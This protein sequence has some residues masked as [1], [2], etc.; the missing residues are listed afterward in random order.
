MTEPGPRAASRDR[1]ALTDQLLEIVHRLVRESHPG[2]TAPPAVALESRLD[3]DLG[4]DSMARAELVLRVERAFNVDLPEQALAAD[5]PAEL[6]EAIVSAHGHAS[7]DRPQPSP[8]EIPPVTGA[9]RQ[10]TTLTDALDWHLDRHADRP[11]LTIY[12]SDGPPETL[13]YAE[14][15]RRARTVA[16]GLTARGIR[17]GDALALMLPTGAEYFTAFLAALRIGAT[18]VPIYPPARASQLEE[19]LRRHGRILTNAEVRVL[20]TVAEARQV[21]RLLRAEAP[22]LEGIVTVDEL[23]RPETSGEDEAAGSD[24][25][26]LLQYTS[27]STGDP[28]GVTLTHAQLLANIRAMGER[29]DVTPEDVF[30]SW[31]PL[32]HD[33]GLIAAWLGSL[34]YAMPLVVM[35]PLGFLARPLRW[36]EIIH[37][38][39]GTISGGPN[40]GYELCLRAITSERLEGV[41]L[42]GWRVAFNGA[43]PV[44]PVTMERFA[45]AFAPHGFRREALMPVYGLA[46]AAVG[47]CVPTPGRGPVSDRVGRE[48]FVATGKAEPVHGDEPA[49]TFV[50][51]GPPLS[52]HEVRIVGAAGQELAERR[53]GEI[54]FRGPSATDGYLYNE[55]ATRSLYDGPWLRTGDRGYLVGGDVHISGR[56]KDVIVRGGR[57]VYP[58]ELEEA[59]GRLQGVRKGCVAVFGNPDAETGVEALVVVAETRVKDTDERERLAQAIREAT[60]DI[61]NLPADDVR[62]VP[63]HSV[64]KTSSGKIRRAATRELYRSAR[65][66]A[67]TA[68]AWWQVLRLATESAVT[69][70]RARTARLG[71][72]G[73]AVYAWAVFG[74]MATLVGSSAVVLPRR[75]WRWWLARRCVRLAAAMTGIRIQREGIEHLTDCG[76]CVLVA[77]HASYLDA[78]VLTA[79]LP[80]DFRYL[81]KRELG[82]NAL[83][84]VLLRRLGTLFV[85]RLDPQ[86]ASEDTQQ[87]FVAIER[88]DS[89]A[90]FPEGTLHRGAGLGAFHMGAF[91]AAV[92]NGIAVVPV[93]LRGT[94]SLMRGSDW[95]PR[96]GPVGVCVGAPLEPHSDGWSE[97]VRLR[98]ASRTFILDRCG[99]PDL[100][101]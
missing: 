73:Y 98:E 99:E 40:F 58:Y 55:D 64:L 24:D 7:A 31:L 6:L 21:A 13:S 23:T 47:L 82:R 89:L 35:S 87:A 63:P 100:A 90:V 52:G 49:L 37:Q 57:N 80:R 45:E 10:A 101:S 3:R 62:L 18:P 11:H 22:R 79:A 15:D 8:M 77:N 70:L 28:K 93:A 81:A 38:H 43:E 86:A 54:E 34:Y 33:M 71:E 2:A 16:G 32:Y 25:L 50:N 68:A 84:R 51:C 94:R 85:E 66:G 29:L 95:L 74:V 4:L 96:P 88:G 59:V 19:H 17:R 12:A 14:L 20:I 30:V 75:Q 53:E 56:S 26:A 44:S 1:E 27:G 91:V 42:S 9:P 36:L 61:I 65:L 48:K 5:T 78:L 67:P 97:A 41:D 72:W 46:E 60:V 76:P 92:R 83:V 69:R 39:G